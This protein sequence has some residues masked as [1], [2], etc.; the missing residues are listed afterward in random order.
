VGL[1]SGYRRTDIGV[2]PDDWAIKAVGSMGEV[3]AGKALA[4][5]ALGSP[6]PYL[7]TKNVLDGR[8]DL[9]DV[10]HMPMTEPDFARYRLEQRDVLLNE[11]QSLELVG[12]CAMYRGEYPGDCAMQNQLV[13][14]RAHEGVSA[15]FAA[16]L[17]RHCQ[18]T[19][20]FARIALQTT[21][22]AHLGVSRFKALT[23]AWPN[24]SLEQ[25]R[26]SEALTDADAL[27]ESLEQLLAKKRQIKQG[28]MQELLTG[29]KRLPQF[30][31]TPYRETEVGAIPDDWLVRPIAFVADVRT[32]PFGSSLHERDYVDAGTPIVTVEHLGE[33]GLSRENLPLVSEKDCKRLDAYSLHPGDIVFSRVG[34]IDRNALVSAAESGW[35]FSGRLLRLRP[36]VNLADSGYLSH[37]FHSEPFKRRVRTVAVGQTMASLNTQI[38]KGVVVV[39]P[40]L[41]EQTAIAGILSDMDAEIDALEA[42]LAKA[43]AIKQGMMQ[44][45]LTG[46]IRLV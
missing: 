8:I 17:F 11:G 12:R 32:G 15:G 2:F 4:T 40:T 28:A 19:G 22:V 7:R 42:K 34:S 5:N 20:A 39:L 13:R 43:R 26:I 35:L 18:R 24:A 45:L 33:R 21:S 44:E 36:F 1:R 14:F 31:V 38:L 37:Q 46:R 41:P 10:L 27:I 6:R 29:R 23:L 3:R 16:Q 25:E 30:A 9:E